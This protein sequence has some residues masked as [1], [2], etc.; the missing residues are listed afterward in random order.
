MYRAPHIKRR[1]PSTE[2]KFAISLYLT[3]EQPCKSI[4]TPSLYSDQ[5]VYP[6][7]VGPDIGGSKGP[8][9]QSERNEIYKKYADQLVAE[10]VAYPCFCTD[11]E[12][13][14][15]DSFFYSF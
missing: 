13:S 15:C 7:S 9:R 8:Y 6:K 12:L 2:T 1:C 11:E 4:H 10:G 14:E 5:S 3:I